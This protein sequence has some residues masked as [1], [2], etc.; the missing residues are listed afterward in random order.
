MGIAHDDDA[1]GA[2]DDSDVDLIDEATLKI[3]SGNL[4]KKPTSK[5]AGL[6]ISA[7]K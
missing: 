6:V 4:N 2:E 5:V 1:I 7:E 3:E